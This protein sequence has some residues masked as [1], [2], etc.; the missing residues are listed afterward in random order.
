MNL[1]HKRVNSAVEELLT[2]HI[3]LDEDELEEAML[4]FA[5]ILP[6]DEEDD[7]ESPRRK[8][9]YRDI[10]ELLDSDE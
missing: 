2:E 8:H 1:T 10:E 6:E 9:S 4:A 5:E 7:S 3:G